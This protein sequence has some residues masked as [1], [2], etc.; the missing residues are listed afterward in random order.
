MQNVWH[1]ECDLRV[2]ATFNY[3]LCA[4]TGE[5]RAKWWNVDC[6]AY[7][8]SAMVIIPVLHADF[9]VVVATPRAMEKLSLPLLIKIVKAPASFTS[10][11]IEYSK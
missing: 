11:H 1:T 9:A 10:G 2:S 7:E 4:L 3:L 6:L 5:A 8:K